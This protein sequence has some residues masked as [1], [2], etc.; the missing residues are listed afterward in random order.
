MSPEQTVTHVSG[1]DLRNGPRLIGLGHKAINSETR[2]PSVKVRVNGTS[3][4]APLAVVS[5]RII[6]AAVDGAA[7]TDLTVT[8]LAKALPYSWAGQEQ[9]IGGLRLRR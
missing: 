2:F 9:S 8:G 5:P 7:P 6:A 1:T 3:A 4:L